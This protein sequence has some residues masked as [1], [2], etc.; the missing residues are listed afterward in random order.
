MGAMEGRIVMELIV[1]DDPN[2][3]PPIPTTDTVGAGA[4]RAGMLCPYCGN[5][6]GSKKECDRCRGVFEPLSRQASQNGMGPWYFRDESNPF[7]PG[8]S[9]ATMRM[10]VMRKRIVAES[11]LRG[12]PTRQFWT[13]AKNTPG[14]AHLLG[15]CHACHRAAI[16]EAAHCPHCNASFGVEED[17]QYLG[18]AEAR[19]IPGQGVPEPVARVARAVSAAESAPSAPAGG[20]FD[21]TADSIALVADGDDGEEARR[22]AYEPIRHAARPIREGP[23]LSET[24]IDDLLRRSGAAERA[25]RSTLVVVVLITLALGAVIAMI[26]FA[27]MLFSGAASTGAGTGGGSGGAPGGAVP[28]T[29]P[30]PA[31]ATAPAGAVPAAPGTAGKK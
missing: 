22:A 13:F 5:Y 31:P 18:L 26:V 4:R 28:A 30:V 6:S 15:E 16:A 23:P 21:H 14:I 20:A 17:R 10:L 19:M 3:P 11:V 7:R 29:T 1:N 8:C 2:M 24:Q 9:Y 25:K 12:P 27:V